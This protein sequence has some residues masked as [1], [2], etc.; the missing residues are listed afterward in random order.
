MR[1]WGMSYKWLALVIVVG[2]ILSGCSSSQ[3][4]N[5]NV[6]GVWK[7]ENGT[8]VTINFNGESK[9]IEMNGKIMPAIIES[10]TYKEMIVKVQEE[11]DK[12]STWIFKKVW[13][14]NGSS[15]TF[16]LSLPDGTRQNLSQETHS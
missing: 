10:D 6:N 2:F 3:Q 7:D 12:L 15:F 8:T 1:K 9:T 14:D 4:A 16:I 11:A 5:T 13:N